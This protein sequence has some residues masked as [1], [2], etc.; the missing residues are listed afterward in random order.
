MIL[1]EW[2]TGRKLEDNS[3]GNI[4]TL[5][6]ARHGNFGGSKDAAGG[7]IVA[8]CEQNL[9]SAKGHSNA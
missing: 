7:C 3:A 9:R 1:A 5:P 8:G 4:R 2:F 6:A